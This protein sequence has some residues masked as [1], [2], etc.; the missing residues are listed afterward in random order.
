MVA[1]KEDR[2]R[3]AETV[4][5]DVERLLS[6]DPPLPHESWRRMRSW[7]RAAV[8]HTLPPTRIILESITEECVELYHTVQP[9]PGR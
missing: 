6:K 1:L 5:E 8:D 2:I 4:G 3:R 7:Y 9:P